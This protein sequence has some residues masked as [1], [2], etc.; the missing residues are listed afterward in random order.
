MTASETPFTAYLTTTKRQYREVVSE[1]QFP[2]RQTF[3]TVWSAFVKIQELFTALTCPKCGDHPRTAIYDALTL[4]YR[5]RH[6]SNL[7]NPPT[8]T[9]SES[10]RVES[11]RAV[12]GVQLLPTGAQ[13]KILKSALEQY[14]PVDGDNEV[15][16]SGLEAASAAITAPDG[17]NERLPNDICYAVADLLG[18]LHETTDGRLSGLLVTLLQQLGAHEM[19]LQFAPH[20]AIDPLRTFGRLPNLQTCDRAT[21]NTFL[22]LCP[23]LAWLCQYYQNRRE[24]VPTQVQRFALSLANRSEAVFASLTNGR[25]VPQMSEIDERS[26]AWQT[27]GSLYGRGPY[28]RRPVYPNLEKKGKKATG[29]ADQECG[30]FYSKYVKKNL[31]GGVMVEWCEHMVATGF[32]C[33]PKAEGR[34][35]VF[36]ALF[37]RW[38]RPPHF[39]IYDFACALATYCW[40]REPYFFKDTMFLIDQMHAEDHTRCTRASFLSNYMSVIPE[41]SYVNSSTAECGNKGLRRIRKTVSYCKES[42]AILVIHTFICVWN[43]LRIVE[44]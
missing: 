4:G 14:K 5:A 22:R 24:P 3:I 18:L 13:R 23:A 12:Q 10:E 35:D 19:V 29:N 6:R 28:R 41:L 15:N 16:I 44:V 38:K 42:T 36:S 30:K 9:C 40:L 20:K 25:R 34:N 7:L 11:V 17:S 27:T 8:N 39:V 2:C 21:S 33:I 26:D 37:T 32:H 1:R 43:R 31:T